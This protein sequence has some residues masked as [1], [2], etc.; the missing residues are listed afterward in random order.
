MAGLATL[1]NQPAGNASGVALAAMQLLPH[2][3]EMSSL[4]L[5]PGLLPA[6]V[7]SLMQELSE[8][9]SRD[10]TSEPASDGL[11]LSGGEIRV[12][13]RGDGA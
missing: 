5:R 13:A 3:A 7:A 8:P 12:A 4:L 9:P 2:C 10:A 1:G 6:F 11:L